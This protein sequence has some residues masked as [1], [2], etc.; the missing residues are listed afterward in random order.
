MTGGGPG[1]GGGTAMGGGGGTAAF[2]IGLEYE[3]GK[4]TPCG[5]QSTGT[6]NY[7]HVCFS[8]AAM[9]ATAECLVEPSAVIGTGSGTLTITANSVVQDVQWSGTALVP[10]SCAPNGTEP[11]LACLVIGVGL[12]LF[13]MSAACLDLGATGC[14]CEISY[15]AKGTSGIG[16]GPDTF[17]LTEKG[18]TKTYSF[19][20][21]NGSFQYQDS[22]KS[23]GAI[24][25]VKP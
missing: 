13:G 8:L 17:Q 19:C 15:S 2:D 6:W 20:I 22:G 4:V 7:E 24:F 14:F 10:Q 23:R 9:G 5:G 3:C 11:G 21:R 1:T 12:G 25:T 18:S 16:A